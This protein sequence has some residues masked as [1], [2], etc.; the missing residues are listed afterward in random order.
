MD[1][2]TTDV[3]QTVEY[4]RDKWTMNRVPWALLG[5]VVGIWFVVYV[6]PQPAGLGILAAFA[7]IAIVVIFSVGGWLLLDLI[8]DGGTWLASVAAALIFIGILVALFWNDPS[9]FFTPIHPR[10][11]HMPAYVGGWFMIIIS[12]GWIAFALFRHFRPPRPLVTLTPAG[13]T[14]HSELVRNLFIPWQEVREVAGLEYEVPPGYPQHRFPDTT[15]VVVSKEFCEQH[16]LSQ[17]SLSRGPKQSWDSLLVPKG[18][19]MQIVVPLSA[20]SIQPKEVREPIEARW[21]AFRSAPR[22]EGP[23]ASPQPPLVYGRWKSDGSIWQT[24]AFGVPLACLI[25]ILVSS[26]GVFQR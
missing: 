3:F 19:A 18:Q 17:R 13:L 12:L 21:K 6:D 4:S 26:T 9:S 15:A 16:I 5:C 23:A 11:P 2:G 14:F 22:G 25:G 7:V 24:I 1:A 20:I 10:A 8:F